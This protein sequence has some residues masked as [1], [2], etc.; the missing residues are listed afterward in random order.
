MRE[1]DFLIYSA[2]ILLRSSL[3][4]KERTKEIA[5]EAT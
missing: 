3:I 1:F 2:F 5:N 4:K